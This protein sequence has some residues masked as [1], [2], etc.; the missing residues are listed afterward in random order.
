MTDERPDNIIPFPQTRPRPRLRFRIE[1]VMMPRP[2]WRCIEVPDDTTFWD[3]HVA[4]QS[5]MGWHDRH[6]HLF[7]VDDP[8][9]GD[10]LLFGIP[11]DSGFHGSDL[12]L[13]GWAHAVRTYFLPDLPPALYTYDFGEDWQH[14]VSLEA[15]GDPATAK[16][17]PVCLGGEGACPPEDCGGPPGYEQMLT[18]LSDP[19]D[20]GYEDML[21][22]LDGP[23]DPDHFDP[24]AVRF[25]DPNR[26]WRDLFD[27]E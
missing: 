6:L 4:I 3:L 12:V 2:V 10:H 22:W 20:D 11:D 23:F 5:V 14:E 7:T 25:A 24:A 16:A 17:G 15:L 18:T 13:P 19:D 9:S 26:R 8:R 1:L 21:A 27:S